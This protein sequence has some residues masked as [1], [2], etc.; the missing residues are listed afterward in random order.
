MTEEKILI[1]SVMALNVC[2]KLVKDFRGGPEVKDL[3]LSLLWLRSDPWLRNF[4]MP[5]AWPKKKVKT[6]IY[7]KG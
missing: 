3:A 2:K 4:C 6:I 5:Q 7:G 1:V